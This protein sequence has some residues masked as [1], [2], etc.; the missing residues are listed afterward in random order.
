LTILD[1]GEE[2][3]P[4]PELTEDLLSIM[5]SDAAKLDGMRSQKQKELLE[6]AETV[7]R[8]P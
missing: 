1:P 4:E 7:L 8:S 2:N 6:C 5:A 3:T